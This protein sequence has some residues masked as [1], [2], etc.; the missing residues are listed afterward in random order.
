MVDI[1]VAQSGVVILTL[2]L[3]VGKPSVV[4]EEH[5]NAQSLGLFHEVGKYVLVEVERR[6][7]PVVKQCEAVSVTV[8]Q[9]PVASPFMQVAASLRCAFS[10][11]RE[12]ELRCGE[13]LVG[14]E[15]IVA[16]IWVDARQDA[17]VAHVVNLKG[18]AEVARPSECAHKNGAMLLLHLISYAKLEERVGVHGG[19]RAELGVNYFLAVLQLL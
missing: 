13:H 14:L 8:L 6:V 7:L 9:T 1:P 12:D 5:V 3:A 16:G 18:E 2:V 10:A 15:L 4:E 17:Q 19:T 11:E